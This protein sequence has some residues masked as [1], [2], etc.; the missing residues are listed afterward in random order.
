MLVVLFQRMP[1]RK[2][3]L[4]EPCRNPEEGGAARCGFQMSKCVVRS[5]G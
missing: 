1:G 2:K 3:F 4:L 5:L